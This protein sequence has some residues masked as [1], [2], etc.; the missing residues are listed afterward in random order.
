[1]PTFTLCRPMLSLAVILSL[2]SSHPTG[3]AK[4]ALGAESPEAA[5]ERYWIASINQ[6]YRELGASMTPEMRLGMAATVYSV[7]T[8]MIGSPEPTGEPGPSSGSPE[9]KR[10][11][12]EKRY[13][14]VATKHGLPPLAS[15]IANLQPDR[16]V[17]LDALTVLADFGVVLADYNNESGA[18]FPASPSPVGKLTRLK[19]D[20][21]RARGKLGDSSIEFARID[22]RWFIADITANE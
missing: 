4:V 5:L 11:R 16:I 19:M 17:G 10:T 22:G 15:A 9:T 18:A 8:L 21:S 6:D 1:M 13:N 7:I 20:G 2:F 12:W 3:A 14:Q